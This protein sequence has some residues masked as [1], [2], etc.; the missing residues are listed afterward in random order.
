MGSCFFYLIV[1]PT[2]MLYHK[3]CN[4][5]ALFWEVS[6]IDLGKGRGRRGKIGLCSGVKTSGGKT[7]AHS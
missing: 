3:N 1:T 5:K 4:L 7:R 6:R 2:F